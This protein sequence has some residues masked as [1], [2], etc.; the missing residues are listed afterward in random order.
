MRIPRIFTAQS[1]ALSS[2]LELE[3][4][5]SHHLLKVLRMQ[6]GRELTLFNNSGSEYSAVITAVSKKTATV[7]INQQ[8]DI[9]RESP[10]ETE[11][12]IG[13]S[14]GDRFD[15]V[16]QKVTELG[17][18]RIVPLFTE[19]TEVKLNAERLEKRLGQWQ[20]ITIA[21]CEQ[22]QRNTLPILA[23]PQP[24]DEYLTACTSEYRFV[25]H[26]RAEASLNALQQ[27]QS[28]ALLIGPEGGLSDN[29]ITHAEQQGFKS[30]A[31]GPRVFRTE[32]APIAALSI[33]Q[34]LWGD[35]L[36]PA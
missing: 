33:V 34:S 18:T 23:T 27:P 11:L 19:R 35:L 7:A 31:L 32:T 6:P 26:H 30:L 17:I 25:L 36:S 16:L 13:I 5:A 2:E 21:A 14:R 1:L 28:V 24:L 12:A 22:C 4:S 29:E 15:W 9:D 8:S 10:L 3:E 20:K